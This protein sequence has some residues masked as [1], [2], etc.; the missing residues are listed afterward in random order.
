[1]HNSAKS[2][3]PDSNPP[4]QSTPTNALSPCWRWQRRMG[5][6]M[7]IKPGNREGLNKRQHTSRHHL[8]I[9][10]ERIQ[11][12]ECQLF[13]IQWLKCFN[14]FQLQSS[15][16]FKSLVCIH[17]SFRIFLFYLTHYTRQP[18][19]SSKEPKF[20]LKNLTNTSCKSSI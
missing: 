6:G 9:Q 18:R 2:S 12:H 3:I 8:R 5:T 4:L 1:M 13:N 10:V 7:Q 11:K 15:V 16:P 19:F 14:F 20:F 17:I